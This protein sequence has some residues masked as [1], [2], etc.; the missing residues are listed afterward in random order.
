MAAS[1]RSSFSV[2]A[3]WAA[4]GLVAAVAILVVVGSTFLGGGDDDR[5]D[6]AAQYILQVNQVQQ[7]MGAA[8]VQ[9]NRAYAGLRL[10][11]NGGPGQLARL[12]QAEA[13]MRLLGQQVGALRPPADAAAVHGELERLMRM[14]I[15]L[16]HE[17]TELGRYVTR[18]AD[19]ERPLAV[20]GARLRR[21]LAAEPT[22]EAQARAFGRY[23][24]TLR[25]VAGDMESLSAPPVLEP[26]RLAEAARLRRIARLTG[27]LRAALTDQR[28]QS[29]ARLTQEL[30]EETAVAGASRAERAAVAAY[31]RRLRAIEQQR[32]A[33][34]RARDRLD[35]RLS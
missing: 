26:A 21:E 4:V 3:L 35:R 34:E 17:L 14:Q 30:A 9:V 2:R 8:L 23:G 6:A 11:R 15:A 20:A 7:G 32:V 27:E 19:A 31:R 1:R 24:V 10:G 22:P 12:E 13:T 28:A 18:L 16:A 33:V 29:V 25:A 5:R